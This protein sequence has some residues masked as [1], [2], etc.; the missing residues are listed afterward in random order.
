[1]PSEANMAWDWM[2]RVQPPIYQLR[3]LTTNPDVQPDDAWPMP[4][5]V[6]SHRFSA[7]TSGKAREPGSWRH[8][9]AA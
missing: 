1:M 4:V 8:R 5:H 3:R 9:R 7:V 2:L 6:D